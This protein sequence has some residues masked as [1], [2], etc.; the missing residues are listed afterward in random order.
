MAVEFKLERF[1][2][3]RCCKTE[4]S[5]LPS[6]AAI[7]SFRS[8]CLLWILSLLG[9]LSLLSAAMSLSSFLRYLVQN[10]LR[11]LCFLVVSLIKFIT[12]L[13]D[14]D[15]EESAHLLAFLVRQL[16]GIPAFSDWFVV[17]KRI[18]DAR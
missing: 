7:L 13:L 10:I 18:G 2:V 8:P 4:A 6:S 15:F 11:T 17:V 3:P 5:F 14:G 12:S 16:L 9:H 1:S